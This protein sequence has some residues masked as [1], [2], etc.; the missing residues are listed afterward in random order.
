MSMDDEA[1]YIRC[2][3]CRANLD[4]SELEPFSVV[5]CPVCGTELR[6]PKRFGRYLLDRVCGR[7][8]F[9]TVYRAIDPR[10][11]RWVAVKMLNCAPAD[12]E[13]QGKRFFAEAKLVAK[14]NHPNILP[15]YDCGQIDGQPYLTARYMSGGDLG[16]LIDS[17]KPP[18]P[19]QMVKIA[20]DIATALDY[21]YQT[22]HV[23]HH[24]VNPSNIL[25]ADPDEV[26]LGD[27]DIADIREP[28]DQSTPCTGWATPA[29][30]S[31]ERLLSGGEDI[32]GDIFSLGVTIYEALGWGGPFGESEDPEE[33]YELRRDMAFS[34]LSEINNMVPEALSDLVSRM[35][36]FSPD[37][38]PGY[39]EL[40]AELMR[41][42][43]NG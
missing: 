31:P 38:R 11:A 16:A 25:L 34:K 33:L 14:L 2:R 10:L 1:L 28:G 13:E 9:T 6:I 35:L 22:E 37:D 15:I 36:A 24:D 20:A 43:D 3:K 39:A 4:A 17:G 32:R 7:G 19:M 40:I 23:V 27:F 12:A 41:I 26:R 18:T 8:S 21:A 30:V 42:L 5:P 29:Y